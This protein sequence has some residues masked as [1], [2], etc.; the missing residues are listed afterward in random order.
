[1]DGLRGFGT[2]GC[3][4]QACSRGDVFSMAG[5]IR[6][7]NNAAKS[8]F[9]QKYDCLYDRTWIDQSNKICTRQL[10]RRWPES[11]SCSLVVICLSISRLAR[12][13]CNW[14]T[15]SSDKVVEPWPVSQRVRVL[16]STSCV[17]HMCKS[18][19]ALFLG[20]SCIR[21]KSQRN[22]AKLGSH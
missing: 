7:R 15:S 4:G 20:Q 17:H 13:S 11:T 8:S 16:S 19:S 18:I 1:M 6:V 14:I 21:V 3:L 2:H 10:H 22:R 5:F 9:L 12:R